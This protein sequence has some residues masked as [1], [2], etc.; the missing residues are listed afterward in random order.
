MWWSLVS[1]VETSVGEMGFVGY[2]RNIQ[3]Y[4]QEV[5]KNSQGSGVH[6][7]LSDV[8]KTGNIWTNVCYPT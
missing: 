2:I 6:K 1:E 7:L 4:G 3:S 5:F 8:Y